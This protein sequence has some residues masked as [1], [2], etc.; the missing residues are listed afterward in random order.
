MGICL[1][2]SRADQPD[3]SCL[4]KP[5]YISSAIRREYMRSDISFVSCEFQFSFQ[6]RL[7][8]IAVE[9]QIVPPRGGALPHASVDYSGVT[10][11]LYGGRKARRQTCRDRD[12]EGIDGQEHGESADCRVW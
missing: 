7:R 4:T 12:A 3:E 10:M 6:R 1:T 11:N 2:D 8:R 9:M 5:F